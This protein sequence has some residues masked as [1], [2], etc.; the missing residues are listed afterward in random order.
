MGL[1]L[2]LVPL[3]AMCNVVPRYHT[4]TFVPY[5]GVF[6]FFMVLFALS[7][8]VATA[9]SIGNC[10]KSVFPQSFY[11]FPSRNA[12]P[13]LKEIAGSLLN[14]FCVSSALVGSIFSV[15]IINLL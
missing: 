11:I 12:A 7:H 8:G 1:R 3:I 10:A 5:D 4:A 9:T 14:V 2:V 13:E 6:L 15:F